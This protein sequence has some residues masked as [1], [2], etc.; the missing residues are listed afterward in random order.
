MPLTPW[1]KADS[2]GPECGNNVILEQGELSVEL[3]K[4][5]R[6]PVVAQHSEISSCDCATMLPLNNGTQFYIH[7]L[8]LLTLILAVSM[9]YLS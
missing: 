9:Q 1:V 3:F 8:L 5:L 7:Q 2:S 6:P 4:G